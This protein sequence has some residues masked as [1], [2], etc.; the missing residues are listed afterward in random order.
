MSKI[1]AVVGSPSFQSRTRSLVVHVQERVAHRV[2]GEASIVDIAELLSG[3]IAR[4]RDDVS[5]DVTQALLS[6][7]RADLLLVGTPVYKGSYTGLFKHFID[8][9]D[10]KALSGIPVGLLATGGSDRHALVIEHQLR[11]LFGFFNAHTLPTGVFVPDKAFIDGRIQD[12]AIQGRLT[13]LVNEAVSAL[14]ARAS[15][16][17]HQAA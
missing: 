3:L 1:V 8:L 5:L 2:S 12:Q 15:T 11:P 16:V 13:T 14:Q 6:V 4:S 17:G 10:Y 7:E 9:I